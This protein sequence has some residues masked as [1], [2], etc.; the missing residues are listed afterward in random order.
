M[1]LLKASCQLPVCCLLAAIEGRVAVQF[2]LPNSFYCDFESSQSNL[3]HEAAIAYSAVQVYLVLLCYYQG[4]STL[5]LSFVWLI[6]VFVV[7][8]RGVLECH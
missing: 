8:L 4:I 7:D 5:V 6:L 1:R 3:L 2:T